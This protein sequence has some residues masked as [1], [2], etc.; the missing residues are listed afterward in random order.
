M[1]EHAVTMPSVHAVTINWNGL[2]DT[3]AC[4][5]SLKVQDYRNLKIHVVDNDSDESEPVA[6]AGAHPD[7]E[8]LRQE[9]N[10]GFC[11]GNNVAIRRALEAGADYVLILNNDTI[12][13]P[14]LISELVASSSRLANVGAVSPVILCYPETDIVWFAGSVW[15]TE[16]AGFRH[17]LAGCNRAE[18]KATEPFQSLYAC[19]CCMLVSANVLR[20]IGLMDER[21]FAYYDEADWCSRMT[22]A[23]LKCYVVPSATILHKV[24]RS[25]PGLISA[26]LMARNRL[27]WM[28][29]HLTLRERVRSYPYL[30]KETLWNILNLCGLSFGKQHISTKHSRV[31]LMA[32][33]DFLRRRFGRWPRSIDEML[34]ESKTEKRSSQPAKPPHSSEF[35]AADL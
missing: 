20:Q 22:E 32:L 1:L 29:E 6:L 2:S 13:P 12:V 8:I 21:Y 33:R 15:E 16:T 23:G 7:V 5:D 17:L 4:L 3:L 19:G 34:N 14:P 28:K 25:T 10:L 27:L 18:Q 9:T 26:Y 24:S 31:M 35:P 30:L 11:G